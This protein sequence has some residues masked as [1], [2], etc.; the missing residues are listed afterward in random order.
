MTATWSQSEPTASA[1]G[2]G[3]DFAQR[4]GFWAKYA[5]VDSAVLHTAIRLG[6]FSVVP[7]QGSPPMDPEALAERLHA[8]M[9]GI[10][11]VCE[12]LV[13]TG[14]LL[15]D[16]RGRLTIPSGHARRLRHPAEMDRMREASTWWYA[17]RR[18]AD[19][20]RSDS[21]HDQDRNARR[22]LNRYIQLFLSLQPGDPDSLL[23][24]AA[25]NYL[26]SAALMAANE[27][28]LLL[29]L[30]DTW[31]GVD[32]LADQCGSDPERLTV[33]LLTL[34]TLDL[35]E[36]DSTSAA[37]RWSSV[38]FHHL[39]P[40]QLT[41]LQQGLTIAASFW[42]AL[43]Q[44]AAAVVEDRR[45]LDLQDPS[46]S[47]AFY[48]ALARYN[49]TV[50][51]SYFKLASVVAAT[52]EHA[53]PLAGADILDVGSGSGVWGS[54]FARYSPTARVTFLDRAPVLEQTRR[55]VDRL[56]LGQRTCLWP[57]D[58]VTADFGA[59]AF[60]LVLLGQICHTQ[61]PEVLPDLFARLARALRP[62]G[63]LVL[64]DCILDARRAAPLE[65]L[66]FGV[67]EFTSTRGDVLSYPEY[68]RLLE[69]AGFSSMRLYR[70]GGVDV[71][72]AGRDAQA[73]PEHLAQRSS[74]RSEV[75]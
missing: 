37:C 72:L 56:G 57:A 62:G 63:C 34:A 27:L 58:L 51:P 31:C 48:L 30:S 47:A 64:A 18:L 5:F 3:D 55:N 50:F 71:I 53:Q 6:M 42:G 19:V 28:G 8:S 44:L 21:G 38:A 67:K 75:A 15:A 16:E 23:D 74:P 36:L 32:D 20:I 40:R 39:A 9:R 17:A 22:L 68:A 65:Y 73:W 1:T 10:K 61:P 54:A 35:V 11:V 25:R 52:I 14:A 43:G 45:V 59:A 29:A 26:R 69:T 7:E 2:N 33:L 49:T 60:D 24:R 4:L 70:P 46:R 12:P 66:Y 13:A 41:A